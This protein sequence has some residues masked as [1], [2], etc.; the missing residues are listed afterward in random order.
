MHKRILREKS[1]PTSTGQQTDT[2]RMDKIK[3]VESKVV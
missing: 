2:E 3:Y 1:F